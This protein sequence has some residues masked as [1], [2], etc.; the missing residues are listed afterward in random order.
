MDSV[1]S[2]SVYVQ[3]HVAKFFLLNYLSG[4]MASVDKSLCASSKSDLYPCF[5]YN[6]DL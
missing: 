1:F 6:L 5:A 3:I 4:I 2:M